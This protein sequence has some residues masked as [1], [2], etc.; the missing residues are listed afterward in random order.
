MIFLYELH[1]SFCW[2][3]REEK[4]ILLIYFENLKKKCLKYATV[5]NK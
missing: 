5:S 2:K 3:L 4:K 1:K